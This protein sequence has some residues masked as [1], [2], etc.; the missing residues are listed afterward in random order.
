MRNKPVYQRLTWEVAGF[1][2]IGRDCRYILIDEAPAYFQ[3]GEARQIIVFQETEWSACIGCI[4]HHVHE[5]IDCPAPIMDHDGVIDP[6]VGHICIELVEHWIKIGILIQ[7][8]S[9]N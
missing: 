7:T 2:F 1:D 8:Y 4:A 6:E 5:A 9:P 3:R